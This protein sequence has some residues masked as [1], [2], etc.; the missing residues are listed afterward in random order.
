MSGS[1]HVTIYIYIYIYIYF[2]FYEDLDSLLKNS[3]LS[4]EIMENISAIKVESI[5]SE[6]IW[7]HFTAD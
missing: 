3:L 4:S 2:F 5:Y 1:A 6:M 7:Y